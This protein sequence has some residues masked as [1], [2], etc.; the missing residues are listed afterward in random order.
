MNARR[1]NGEGSIYQRSDGRWC[2]QSVLSGKR[3]FVYAKTRRE[4]QKKL[5]DLQSNADQGILPP[6]ERPTV[7]Q[8]LD[9]WLRDIVQPS[10]R[11]ATHASYSQL[12]R[13]YIVPA[14]GRVRIGEL[15][16]SHLQTLYADLQRRGLSASTVQRTH[17][18]LRRSLRHALDT[19]LV[20]RNVASI[21]HP[22]TPR[23]AEMQTLDAEQARALIAMARGTRHEAMLTLALHSG[24]RAGELLGLKWTD[25][26]LD[27][28]TLRVRRQLTKEGDFTEP[29]TPQSRRRID[30]SPSLVNCL[31]EHHSLQMEVRLQAGDRWKDRGLVFCSI[32]SWPEPGGSPLV[33]R[34]VVRDFKKLLRAAGL[35][36]IRFHDLRHTAA[37]LMLL[38]NVPVKVVSERLGHANIVLTLQTYSHALPTMGKDAAE[39]MDALLR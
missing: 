8:H 16:P 2:A 18:V 5:R 17:A 7:Q 15:Q 3:R 36:T 12:A 19:G 28:A 29:K 9:R 30:L 4:V 10:V 21:A 26:D 32:R 27:T 35:P 39:K 24:M 6:S 20:H 37:T 13:L 23:R 25:V 33:Y 11:P 31:R 34:N 14:F 38:Q 1:G 22:P